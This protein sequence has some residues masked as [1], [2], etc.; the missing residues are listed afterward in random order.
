[1]VRNEFLKLSLMPAASRDLVV[2]IANGTDPAA[3]GTG[4]R[5]LLTNKTNGLGC[6]C[7]RVVEVASEIA[8]GVPPA[9]Y[10]LREPTIVAAADVPDRKTKQR[11][12]CFPRIQAGPRIPERKAS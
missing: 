3:V 1:M 9:I 12:V 6:D 10:M 11:L 8:S 7:T 5:E 2:R 4:C